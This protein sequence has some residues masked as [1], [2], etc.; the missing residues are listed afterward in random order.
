MQRI[1]IGV[2]LYLSLSALALAQTNEVAPRAPALAPAAAKSWTD[3]LTARGDVRLRFEQI[4]DDSKKDSDGDTYTRSRSRLRARLGVDAKCSDQLKAGLELSTGAADPVSGNQSMGEGFGKKEMRLSLAYLDYTLLKAADRQANLV[5]GK[6]KNPFLTQ[7]DDLVWDS[8]VTP[9]GAAAKLRLGQGFA[10]LDVNAG[11]FVASERSSQTDAILAAAQ[12]ALKLQFNPDMALTAGAA[13]YNY[14][15]VEGYDVIDWEDGDNA[16]GNSTVAGTVDGETTHKAWAS[17]FT[18]VVAFAQLGA[19][20]LG[21]P[22]ALYAQALTNPEADANDQ[23]Q[24]A[25]FSL[26]QARQPRSFEVGYSYAKLEQDATLGMF[27]DSD[28]WGGGTDGKG[29]KFS[30]KYQIAKGLQAGIAYFLDE[31]KIADP[32]KT[33][34][35]DRLQ[36]DLAA[37][38]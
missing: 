19:K 5:A 2:C 35:Y 26:G 37:S 24:M 15:G 25:G 7:P 13:Y 12:G 33:A 38:F 36:I 1:P 30:A 20:V 28:R 23:G 27:T 14:S 6:M 18:P 32:A 11:C 34:D 4:G 17:G 16:Y 21:L 22:V 10:S 9:E 29:H 3:S 8:D 31:R